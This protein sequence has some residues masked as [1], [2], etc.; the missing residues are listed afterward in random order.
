MARLGRVFELLGG[1]SYGAWSRPMEGLMADTADLVLRGNRGVVLDAAVIAYVRR[2]SHH[3]I[4]SYRS[5]IEFARQLGYGAVAEFLT[6]SLQE[7]ENAE[8]SLSQIAH[9]EINELAAH[10]AVADR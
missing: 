5:A 2:I 6:L 3:Q 9:E 8:E 10:A 7:E 4:A 1:T